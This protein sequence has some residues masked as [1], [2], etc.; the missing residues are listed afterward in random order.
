MQQK[1]LPIFAFLTILLINITPATAATTGTLEITNLSNVKYNFTYQQLSEMPKTTI[2]AE[3]YC[4]GNIVTLGDWSGV[5]L[6]YLLEQINDSSNVNS[7]QFVAADSYMVAIPISIAMAPET[8]IAYEKDGL[9]LSEG[10][11]LVLPGYNGASWIAQ[12]TS[13]T[14]SNNEASTPQALSGLG[15]QGNLASSFVENRQNPPTLT[16]LPNKHNPPS[17]PH[18]IMSHQIQPLFPQTLL[19][20]NQ[21]PNNKP[22]TINQ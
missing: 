7:I 3:L 17:N 1:L 18:L 12:I 16:I 21:H 14:L 20:L 6:S 13:I 15:A 11:R 2:Y 10:L 4:Y 22:L 19:K 8:I 5:Q 9:A